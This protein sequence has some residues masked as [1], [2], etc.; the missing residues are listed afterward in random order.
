MSTKRPH[1]HQTAHHETL[2]DGQREPLWSI[3]T[4]Y[5]TARVRPCHRGLLQQIP[6]IRAHASGDRPQSDRRPQ[7]LASSSADNLTNF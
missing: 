6:T 4:K 2:A 1:G 5:E 7:S 3:T